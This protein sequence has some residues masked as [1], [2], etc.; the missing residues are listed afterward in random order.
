MS[1]DFLD[2]KPQQTTG[3]GITATI[4]CGL[5]PV[6][7]GRACEELLHL[8]GKLPLSI[9]LDQLREDR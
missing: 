5:E 8:R 4:R 3:A 1:A 9:D 6:A 7:A 2:A